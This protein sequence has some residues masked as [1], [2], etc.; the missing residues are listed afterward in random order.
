[1]MGIKLVTIAAAVES[2]VYVG[3]LDWSPISKMGTVGI[4]IL[5]VVALWKDSGK[6]QDK[7]ESVVRE[8]SIVNT[9]VRDAVRQ[10][11]ANVTE[12]SHII[13]KCR[14]PV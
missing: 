12:Q 1:M 9:E 10:L 5:A 13:Q 2:S 4:L 14:G 6:R 3:G 7:L 11:S 8:S